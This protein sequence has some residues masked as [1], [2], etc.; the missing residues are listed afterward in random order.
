MNQRPVLS[1]VMPTYNGAT[2]IRETLEG[3]V[4]QL[5][6]RARGQVSILYRINSF[7]SSLSKGIPEDFATSPTI[8]QEFCFS[9]ANWTCA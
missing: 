7:V 1:I 2:Y 5:E 6:K 8:G 4:S 9:V 3:I